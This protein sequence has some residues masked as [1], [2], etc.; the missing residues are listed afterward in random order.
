MKSSTRSPYW[1]TLSMPG[2]TLSTQR[3]SKD[4]ESQTM[5]QRRGT[6]GE[7]KTK[8]CF[9]SAVLFQRAKDRTFLDSSKKKKNSTLTI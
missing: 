5:T 3:E 6:D 4:G 8:E 2:V 1:A 9:L 7:K